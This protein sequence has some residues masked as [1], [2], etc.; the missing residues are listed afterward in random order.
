MFS[1]KQVQNY[2]IVFSE[3]VAKHIWRAPITKQKTNK[4]FFQCLTS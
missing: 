2:E 1:T 3:Y 4:I